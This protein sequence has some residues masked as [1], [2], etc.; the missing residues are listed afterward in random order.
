MIHK[1]EFLTADKKYFQK[2]K[3]LG[4]IELLQF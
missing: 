1:A 3:Q 4:N 2:A